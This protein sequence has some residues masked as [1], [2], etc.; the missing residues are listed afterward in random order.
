[1]SSFNFSFLVHKLNMTH[2]YVATTR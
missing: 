1:M 2:V